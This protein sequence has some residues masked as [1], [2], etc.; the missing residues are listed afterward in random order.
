MKVDSKGD[1]VNDGTYGLYNGLSARVLR[2][3]INPIEDDADAQAIIAKG[4]Y[5]VDLGSGSVAVAEPADFV[6]TNDG[7]N[8]YAQDGQK[9]EVG[10]QVELKLSMEPA[11]KA[12]TC[13]IKALYPIGTLQANTCASLEEA[14]GGAPDGHWAVFWGTIVRVVKKA[15]ARDSGGEELV[16]WPI[17]QEDLQPKEGDWIKF[18][19]DNNN[20]AEGIVSKVLENGR[21]HGTVTLTVY[22]EKS[23]IG[24]PYWYKNE[25]IVERGRLTDGPWETKAGVVRKGDTVQITSKAVGKFLLKVTSG[26]IASEKLTFCGKYVSGGNE[27]EEKAIKAVSPTTGWFASAV[28]AIVERN[29]KHFAE[30]DW[31]QAVSDDGETLVSG[32]VTG[33]DGLVIE[34]D[35]DLTYAE[36]VDVDFKAGEPYC[37]GYDNVTQHLKDGEL[38]SKAMQ[39]LIESSTG[40]GFSESDTDSS[41]NVTTTTEAEEMA[42]G[43]QTAQQQATN[44]KLGSLTQAQSKSVGKVDIVQEGTQIVLPSK[45]SLRTAIKELERRA[46]Q[47]EMDVN[48]ME[49]IEGFPLDAAHAFVR[50]LE[51]IFGWVNAMPTPGFFG[52]TPPTMVGVTIDPD[53]HTVQIPW[54][55]IGIPGVTGKLQTG[56][57]MQNGWPTFAI[58]GTIKQKDKRVVNEIATF[59]RN[60]LKDN[61]IYKGKAL[62][63]KFPEAGKPFSPLDN[64]PKFIQTSGVK[65][66]ELIFARDVEKRI[67]VNIWTPIVALGA[68]KA[69][70]VPLKRGVLLH[71]RYGVGKTLLA[72][73]TAYLAVKNGVTFIDLEDSRE[74]PQAIRFARTMTGMVVIFAEDID[75]CDNNGSRTEAFNEILNTVDGLT[76]KSDEVMVVYTTNHVERISKAMLRQGRIDKV[77][78]IP[79]PDAEAACRLIRLYARH[80]LNPQEDIT[81]VGKL[82]AEQRMIPAA[83]REIVEQSKLAAIERGDV[84][85]ITADD[86]RITVEDTKEHNELCKEPARDDR[87]EFEKFGDALGTKVGEAVLD[88][89]VAADAHVSNGDNEDVTEDILTDVAEALHAKTSRRKAA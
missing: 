70:R 72:T 38:Y 86:L 73:V 74:L 25:S 17:K 88:A 35:N 10:D 76:S 65:P 3:C 40:I 28:T 81:H 36:S 18:R 4:G 84:H 9:V 31:V 83:I 13:T 6:A 5:V 82:I 7:D 34:L 44:L 27:G 20:L 60:Y 50:A 37:L 75:R 32:R 22:T 48:V 11:T 56:I 59:A 57:Q 85:Q 79:E 41:D 53:G 47:E 24:K 1:P 89:I 39:R 78:S 69:A 52:P 45:M 67:S 14:E 58:Q 49:L 12:P 62:R 61:S 80:M 55:S 66:D 8:V 68:V 43:K 33:D 19:D 64:Q 54:G 71:G 87:S 51:S 16:C 63:I 46:E 30:G 21:Y 29:P 42:Q 15:N 26:R 2:T 77:I 23:R